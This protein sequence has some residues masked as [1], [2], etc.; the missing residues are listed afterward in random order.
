MDLAL[1]IKYDAEMMSDSDGLYGLVSWGQDK[2]VRGQRFHATD[3]QNSSES[4]TNPEASSLSISSKAV[5][6]NCICW[7]ETI[8]WEINVT[9]THVI[10][11]DPQLG[12]ESNQTTKTAQ[13]Q[14]EEHEKSQNTRE[15]CHNKPDPWILCNNPQNT[16]D[17][18]SRT[19]GVR[20]SGDPA[21][22][23]QNFLGCTTGA[24]T[25]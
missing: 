16:E 4:I 13:E 19:T 7:T 20:R 18:K 23:G 22:M 12:N 14:L 9:L 1:V 2:K 5:L 24:C 3:T 21:L 11:L 10:H 25:V 15:R 8:S 17:L 6:L